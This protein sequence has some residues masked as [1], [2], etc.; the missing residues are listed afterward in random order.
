[1]IVD[2]SAFLAILQDEPE[3]AVFSEKLAA[4][5]EVNISSATLL[6]INIIVD[7]RFGYEGTRD[8][9]LLLSILKVKVRS[10]DQDQ[11]MIAARAYKKYGKGNHPAGL[12]YGDCFSYALAMYLNDSLL[13]KGEDFSKTDV[14]IA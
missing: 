11:A 6:E 1:M 14:I 12:N 3:Q 4:A 7:K 10:F 13:F 2:T 5:G 9:E 8:L